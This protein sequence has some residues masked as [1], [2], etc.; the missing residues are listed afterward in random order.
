[1]SRLEKSEQSEIHASARGFERIEGLQVNQGG[2][3]GEQT[4]RHGQ[5]RDLHFQV[6][7][8]LSFSLAQ[9]AAVGTAKFVTQTE[10][11]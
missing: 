5:D 10:H 4:E 3:K 7:S 9:K 1:M 11:A 8:C 6:R 2:G